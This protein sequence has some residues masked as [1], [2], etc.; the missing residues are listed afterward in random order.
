MTPW[1]LATAS[2]AEAR[3][4]RVAERI[5]SC[6][7]P[8]SSKRKKDKTKKI[9]IISSKQITMMVRRIIRPAGEDWTDR[10]ELNKR[11]IGGKKKEE[12]L[13]S[14]VWIV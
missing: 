13:M 7:F 12:D 11:K 10:L 9:A 4:T 8:Y 3:R 5:L 6:L 14:L 1:A 2:M